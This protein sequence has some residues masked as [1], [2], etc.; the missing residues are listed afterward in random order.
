MLGKQNYFKVEAGPA[1]LNRPAI[2]LVQVIQ[3]LTWN[4]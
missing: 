4:S 1:Q 2:S 3:I